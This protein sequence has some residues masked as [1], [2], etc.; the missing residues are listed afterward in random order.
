MELVLFD[1]SR[2]RDNL[3]KLQRSKFILHVRKNYVIIKAI[4]K[5]NGM[6]DFLSPQI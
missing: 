4:L 1:P 5:L 2:Q 3:G 6:V